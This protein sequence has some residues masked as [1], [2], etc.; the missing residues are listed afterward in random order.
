MVVSNSSYFNIRFP[1]GS[2]GSTDLE[3]GDIATNLYVVF[4]GCYQV[5]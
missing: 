4:G 3:Y 5:A 1:S 2:G